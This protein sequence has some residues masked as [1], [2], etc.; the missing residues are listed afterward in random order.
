VINDTAAAGMSADPALAL[1]AA[2]IAERTAYSQDAYNWAAGVIVRGGRA[3]QCPFLT[4]RH[5]SMR[6]KTLKTALLQSPHGFET[7]SLQSFARASTAPSK[8]YQSCGMGWPNVTPPLFM[9]FCS[10]SPAST[11]VTTS[12]ER[13]DGTAG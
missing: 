10:A 7:C 1:A 2:R 11:S 5:S 8:L 4:G 9:S 6:P 12:A 13:L 3:I